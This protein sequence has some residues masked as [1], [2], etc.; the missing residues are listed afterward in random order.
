MNASVATQSPRP[1]T[2]WPISRRRKP[3][4]RR[5]RD[6]SDWP[7]V[8]MCVGKSYGQ[9][10]WAE[11]GCIRSARGPEGGSV[12]RIVT[13]S[14]ANLPPDLAQELRIVVVPLHFALGDRVFRDGVDIRMQEFY[15]QLKDG[16]D[17][18]STAAPS[19]GDF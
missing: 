17:A 6:A 11:S 14:A 5:S 1:D 19:P 10:A 13:D 8:G 16:P 3:V 7:E 9:A 2:A 15:E 12:V 18:A 4:V